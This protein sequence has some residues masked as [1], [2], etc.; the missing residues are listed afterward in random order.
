MSKSSDDTSDIRI[1]VIGHESLG[2][3]EFERPVNSR[4]DEDLVSGNVVS[5]FSA[6]SEGLDS[7]IPLN[8]GERSESCGT[9]ESQR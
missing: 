8:K 7:V 4:E 1:K 3:G 9:V 6:E 5:R 2:L